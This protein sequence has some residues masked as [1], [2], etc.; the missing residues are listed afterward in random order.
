[1]P[2]PGYE[3]NTL[4]VTVGDDKQLD[5]PVRD[6]PRGQALAQVTWTVKRNLSDPDASAV[7]QKRITTTDQVGVGQIEDP[8]TGGAGFVR[9]DYTQNDTNLLIP[10]I[11]YL[12]DIEVVSTAGKKETI[13][14][15]VLLAEAGVTTT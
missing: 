7:W 13:E 9:F 1:M 3:L 10:G 14:K 2:P 4:R 11:E 15:G 5:R 12:Y 8:G 6:V